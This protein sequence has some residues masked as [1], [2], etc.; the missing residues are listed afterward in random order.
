M[1]YRPYCCHAVL[2]ACTIHQGIPAAV[3]YSTDLKV[4]SPHNQQQPSFPHSS[5][6]PCPFTGLRAQLMP[7][8]LHADD[9]E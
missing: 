9:D 6:D 4:H 8:R 7:P 5:T 1:I 3:D 2:S